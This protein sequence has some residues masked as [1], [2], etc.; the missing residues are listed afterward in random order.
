[1][2][3]SSFLVNENWGHQRHLNFKSLVKKIDIRLIL[4]LA[5]IFFYVLFFSYVT[6]SRMFALQTYA[7]DLGVYNQAIHSTLTGHGFLYYTA[8]L[9]ANPSGSIFGVHV[10]FVLLI[11]VP[12]YS[13]FPAAQT[14]LILQSLIL[15]LGA[16]PVYLLADYKLQSKNLALVFSLVYLLSPA[17][18]GINWYDFHPEAFIILP[19]IF[20]I[21]FAEKNRWFP[22]FISI[23]FVLL[24]M[25][26]AAL[27]VIAFGLYKL[28]SIKRAE[29]FKK[30]DLHSPTMVY[31]G[32]IFLGIVWLFITIYVAT[33]FNPNNI[34]V[35]GSSQY[36]SVLGA[37]NIIEIPIRSILHPSLVI[38]ALQFDWIAKFTYLA[39]L[40]G[41]V[42]FL[43]FFAPRSIILVIPWLVVSLLSNY[44]PYYQFGNQYPS[45]ILPAIIC[46]SIIGFSNIVHRLKKPHFLSRLNR[47]FGYAFLAGAL[48]AS[49][50]VFQV[51]SGPFSAFGVARYPMITY[52]FPEP[53]PQSRFVAEALK[54]VP[55]SASILTQNSM[56]PLVSNRENA[57][58]TPTSVFYP[59]NTTF[60]ETLTTILG[61]TDYIIVDSASIDGGLILSQPAVKENFGLVASG[62]GVILV[63]RGYTE[64]PALFDPVNETFNYQNMIP[65]N[66]V[67]TVQDAQSNSR[68]VLLHSNSSGNDFW[69]GPYVSLPAGKYEVSFRLKVEN[70]V[71]GEI[72]ELRVRSWQTTIWENLW[73]DNSAGYHINWSVNSTKNVDYVSLKLYGDNF[74]VGEYQEFFINF[75]VS[76]YGVYEFTGEGVKTPV[77]IYFDTAQ[78]IQ[79][80]PGFAFLTTLR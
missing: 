63:K 51:I 80:E 39:V 22:F 26:K 44:A 74:T 78:V 27:L 55:E 42:L 29:L 28:V 79:T 56:F 14:L 59:P 71:A 34:Y 2:G 32:T 46:G 57:Y 1:L 62:Y 7:Y 10:T 5:A 69:Y 64:R 33:V 72:M 18:M 54:L 48:L 20:A 9:L 15:G 47:K 67:A 61:K 66:G 49:T 43:L 53:T 75:T 25:D 30:P 6:I 8:D 4:L 41:P 45:F 50:F 3:A 60:V 38:S 12:F 76:M 40:F 37:R 36:W 31:L 52:G 58:V 35:C 24:A 77:N 16:L 73:G 68:N 19:M 17:L 65:L 13:L 70:K 23:L 11:I 21:Y